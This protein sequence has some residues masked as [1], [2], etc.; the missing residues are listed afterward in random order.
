MPMPSS[1]RP[2]ISGPRNVDIPQC[3]GHRNNVG[4]ARKRD[5]DDEVKRFVT[6]VAASLDMWR[7]TQTAHASSD[8]ELR[9]WRRSMR[10][11]ASPCAERA[12][13][14]GGASQRSIEAVPRTE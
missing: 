2:G 12:Y 10:S 4:M 3:G 11:Y 5:P 1:D 8:L 9:K 7:R 13:A 14:P 6:E